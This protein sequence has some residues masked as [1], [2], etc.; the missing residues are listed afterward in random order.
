MSLLSRQEASLAG[1][2]PAWGARARVGAELLGS[3]CNQAHAPNRPRNPRAGP[4][5]SCFVGNSCRE[6]MTRIFRP[7]S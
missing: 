3:F 5:A 6:R 7:E 4:T 1:G 2:R